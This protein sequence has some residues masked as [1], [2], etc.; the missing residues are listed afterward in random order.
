MKKITKLMFCTLITGLL[1]STVAMAAPPG[2]Q[3]SQRAASLRS[4]NGSSGTIRVSTQSG[5]RNGLN[6]S[7]NTGSLRKDVSQ[8]ITVNRG[9]LKT[10]AVIQADQAKPAENTGAA[11]TSVK[12]PYGRNLSVAEATGGSGKHVTIQ[13]LPK[14]QQTPGKI[15]SLPDNGDALTELMPAPNGETVAD[16]SGPVN[17]DVVSNIEGHSRIVSRYPYVSIHGNVSE[18]DY[19]TFTQYMD[20]L[21]IEHPGLVSYAVDSGWHIVLTERDLDDLLFHGESEGIEGCTYFPKNGSGGTV[22]IHAGTYSYCIMH[23][24]GHVLDYLS[25]ITSSTAAF[26][27]I[28]ALE[29]NS[30]TKYGE[31]N[32]LEFFAEIFMYTMLQ[33]E[34]TRAACP[35]A[36]DYVSAYID[37]YDDLAA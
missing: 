15:L 25:G 33:P 11:T 29:S 27:R 26:R 20:K 22:F 6:S 17:E 34:T 35:K 18:E 16:N 14:T 12:S 23:E 31:S 4:G 2:T 30:L 7:Q 10:K 9:N 8:S 37:K 21:L 13:N 32:A 3:A 28:Y 36:Y 24:F 1:S 5:I 19:K